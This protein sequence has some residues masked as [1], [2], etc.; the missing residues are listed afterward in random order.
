MRLSGLQD[1]LAQQTKAGS[2]IHR[3]LDELETVDLTF[4]D[5][6]AVG[7]DQAGTHGD[8][9]LRETSAKAHQTASNSWRETL[10]RQV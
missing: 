10:S 8:I 6:L 1:T 9:I 5:A 7:Q 2:A 4:D 3:A